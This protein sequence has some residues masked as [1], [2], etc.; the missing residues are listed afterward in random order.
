MRLDDLGDAEAPVVETYLA[1]VKVLRTIARH[2]IEFLAQLENFQ[3]K[4]W[5]KKKFVVETNYCIT[6][7]RIPEA[8][9][10]QIA[11]NAEQREEWVKLFAIDQIGASLTE[12]GYSVPLTVDFLKANN[13]LAVD[14]AFYCADFTERLLSEIEN[15]D[16]STNGL[17]L[18]S[19]NFQALNVIQTKMGEQVKCVY[20]DPPY[21][22]S[23]E[24]FIYKNSYKHSSW[25]SMIANNLGN[26]RK[27]LSEDGV[28]IQTIDD[29]ELYN[30]KQ[31]TDAS[32]GGDKFIGNVVIQI[33]PR[34]RGINNFFAT[35]HD[36][37]LFHAKNPSKAIIYDQDLTDEQAGD[38]NFKDS[39][40]QYRL[41]PF[42]RSGGLSTPDERP[43]SEFAIYFDKEANQLVAVGGARSLP[44][45]ERYQ[46]NTVYIW[47]TEIGKAIELSTQELPPNFM[48]DLICIMPVDS[49]G[50]RRVWRWSDREKILEAA[51]NGDFIFKSSGESYSIQLKDRIKGGRKP[52]TVWFD[53]KYDASSHGTNLLK[54]IMGGRKS[55]GYPKSLYAT[56]DAI[57]CIVGKDKSATVVDGFG[58]SGTTAHAV[59]SL[60]REDD[61]NRKFIL[62]EMGDY[63]S[64][65]TKP[66]IL[67]S[68]YSAEWKSGKPVGRDGV[69]QAI[70]YI[71]LESY[72]DALN[73]L[74][75]KENV[76]VA[77]SEDFRRDYML[78]YWLEFETQSSPS[79]LNIEA[80]SD[81]AAYKLKVKNP[82]SDEY[83]NKNVD[84]VE[85]FNWLIGL[86]VE[87][88][89]R[90]RG[91]NANT[92]REEDPELPEDSTTRLILDGRMVESD[93]GAWHFRKV[94]G[95]TLPTPGDKSIREKTLV[96][97]RK[98]TGDIEADNLMLD[99]WFKKYRLS[100]QD[101]EFDVIYVNGSNNL[102]NLRQAEETWK[103]R[104]IEEHFH[105]RMWDME[106]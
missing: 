64:E 93:E 48:Q 39:T 44:Y 66:R 105:T 55:F 41:L 30:L 28:L 24:T 86:H 76:S 72:E 50:D 10:G 56:K 90:W 73:N 20:N 35:S 19:E 101:T 23:E 5:L 59:I 52:K 51:Q 96:I 11:A 31:L 17:L 6:L 89:D 87:H 97:W 13:K 104:L 83:V 49:N 106:G 18:H 77:V 58:G 47:S 33:N 99:E 53:S 1:K 43:N 85:T 40:S 74:F 68:F 32:W 61:G 3:K 8:F 91:Y 69:S 57:H 63:F 15:L 88:L 45:P 78:K 95:Y 46:S 12:P 29:A 4:L 26:T 36:Y 102:P 81:P 82:G 62:S 2:L 16:S 25:M 79:L 80:F 70:K 65:V 7:D 100:T 67:K 98:L 94:E 38:F 37:A 92:K 22:T 54:E 60:N 21:N 75:F 9:Y 14:T 103:V 84:L 42:R 71:R 34:G 27:L